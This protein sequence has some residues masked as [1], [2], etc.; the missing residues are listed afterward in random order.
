MAS[1][2]VQPGATSRAASPAR[3]PS[4]PLAPVAPRLATYPLPK[5]TA[6]W[7]VAP[8]AGAADALQL[9]ECGIRALADRRLLVVIAAGAPDAARLSDEIAW[10]A[11][12][13]RVA[14]LPDWE[15]LPYDAFSPH[16]DLISE[17]LSTLWRLGRNEIDVVV[18]AASTAL[19][20][21]A[22]P[23]FLA[24]HAFEFSKGSTLDARGLRA[25]LVLAGY[26]HVAQVIKPGEYSVRGG[27]IDL[28][29]MG[30][31]L[32]YRID[33]F[34]DDV[35]SIRAFDPDTQRTLY[36]VESVRLLPGREFPLDEAA[37]TAFRS[38]WR[39]RFEGDPSRA[40]VYRDLGNGIASGGIEYW[41]PL[42][43]ETTATLFDYLPENALLA[44]H[45]DVETAARGFRED[46][47]NRWRFL[48]HDSER[49]LLKPE[50]L[51]L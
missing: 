16:Q 22:P 13:L 23:G 44:L 1:T 15:T 48:A 6:A 11:P 7:S 37:R 14:Q 43:F 4:P 35:D 2:P 50:E 46:A 29:P 8:T 39:E 38:R 47:Q 10:F 21:L 25:Q 5:E 34:D 30:S 45:G 20:R 3:S 31:P 18:L 51:F 33:L 28:F 26:D 19:Q 40:P 17:R 42:F 24:A 12:D 32:P 9:A 49:P 41:L 36:P 27:L